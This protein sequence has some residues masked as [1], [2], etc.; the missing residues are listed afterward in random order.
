MN[1]VLKL[2]DATV[3]KEVGFEVAEPQ[4]IA[5][6]FNSVVEDVDGKKYYP[7]EKKPMTVKALIRTYSGGKYGRSGEYIAIVEPKY[8]KNGN[9]KKTDFRVVEKLEVIKKGYHHQCANYSESIAEVLEEV[10]DDK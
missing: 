6:E 4:W 8:F 9:M 1:D 7:K 3:W 10:N 5:D 2:E